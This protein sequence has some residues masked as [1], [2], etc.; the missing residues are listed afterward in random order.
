MECPGMA[1]KKHRSARTT[2]FDEVND[3]PDISVLASV[4]SEVSSMSLA[5]TPKSRRLIKRSA[6][7]AIEDPSTETVQLSG[8]TKRQTLK[9]DLFFQG[10]Q[11]KEH[12]E[13]LS[14]KTNEFYTSQDA[15]EENQEN[16]ENTESC[17]QADAVGHDQLD[18]GT[19]LPALVSPLEMF[20]ETLLLALGG[21]I[22]PSDT[23]EGPWPPQPSQCSTILPGTPRSCVA[24]SVGF[25]R[26]A[27]CDARA[28]TAPA[29]QK[30]G[31]PEDSLVRL[32]H[33]YSARRPRN[34]RSPTRGKLRHVPPGRQALFT[35]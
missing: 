21:P 24:S 31:S 22:K 11:L 15:E 30:T 1:A 33:V 6:T 14:G 10:V 18:S 27:F 8:W 16:T 34:R 12:A 9:T 7:C 5:Q 29:A 23:R 26:P 2:A 19:K 17:L 35:P 32:Q 3:S 20:S 4:S 28:W 13:D 25:E